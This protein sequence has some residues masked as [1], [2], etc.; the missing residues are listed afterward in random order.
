MT[1]PYTVREATPDDAAFLVRVIDMASEGLVPALWDAMAPKGTNGS[2]IGLAMVTAEDGDFSYRHGFV[3][4]RDGTPLGG[5]IGYPLPTTPEPIGPEVP[6]VF[7]PVKQ[8]EELVPGYWYINVVAMVPESRGIGLGTNLLDEAEARA[9]AR[10]CPGLA[11]VVAASNAGAIRAYTR[12]GYREKA[13]RPFELKDFGLEPTEAL[14][15]VREL[16]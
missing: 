14:L 11:L 4:E 7:V 2:E 1:E 5:L 12:A 9:R 10:E 16:T 3:V 13:R 6:E 15:L 8:L